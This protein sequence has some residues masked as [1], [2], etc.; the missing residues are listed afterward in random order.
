MKNISFAVLFAVSLC[1]GTSAALAQVTQ[2]ATA[3]A[4]ADTGVYIRG[5]LGYAWSA[6]DEIDYSPVWGL[7]LGYRFN[8]NLRAD[9]TFDWRD[10]F[11]L[12][13][14]SFDTKIENQSYMLNVYYDLDQLPVVQLPGGFKPYVGAG[15]GLSYIEVNDQTIPGPVGGTVSRVFGDDEANF[16]WQLMAGVAYQINPKFAADIGYRY[17]HLGEA[18]LRSPAGTIDNDL[19]THEIVLTLRYTF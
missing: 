6:E 18:Q 4:D 7:G 9:F 17:A 11:I 19:N 2:P 12:E 10:R 15:I 3:R 5:S 1:M 13:T 14:G 16:A 8:R